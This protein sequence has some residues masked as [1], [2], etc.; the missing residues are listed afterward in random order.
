MFLNLLLSFLIGLTPA[1]AAKKSKAK[2]SAAA[3]P[4]VK[5]T[6]VASCKPQA[7]SPTT[8]E[9]PPAAPKSEKTL[10]V[11]KQWHLAPTTITKGFKEKYRQEKNQT[12]IYKNLSDAVKKKRLDLVI[13]EGCQGEINS[14]FET[15]FNGWTVEDL[16]KQSHTRNFERIVAHVP[17]KLEAR[18]GD[19]L[20]TMCGDD[21]KQIQEGNMRLSNLRGWMG[22][23]TRL[24]EPDADPE[25]LKLYTGAAAD[26]LKMPK[27]TPIA[28][29]KKKIFEQATQE[30]ELFN[31]TLATRN[32]AF[33]KVAQ[34]QEFKTGAIVIGGLH[35]ADLVS[36]LEAAG[37]T[38]DVYEPTG[39]SKEDENLIREFQSELARSTPNS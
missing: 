18:W 34:T 23:W 22:F 32:D 39:Y 29:L 17:M 30:L 12:S 3:S 25:R 33:V 5:M 36:K 20:L 24:N 26:L 28:E 9:A 11:I 14:E 38:C 31:K 13:A 35:A 19:K 6:K 27:E 1:F 21:E 15:A 2:K 16:K 10:L 8:E 37:L 4:I 7:P